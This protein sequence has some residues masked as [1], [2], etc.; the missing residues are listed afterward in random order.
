MHFYAIIKRDRVKATDGTYAGILIT[1]GVH[2]LGAM[3]GNIVLQHTANVKFV[4]SFKIVVCCFYSNQM[5]INS[6]SRY[7]HYLV[8]VVEVK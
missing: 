4:T 8:N 1:L 6:I 7:I 5:S 3:S 2:Y